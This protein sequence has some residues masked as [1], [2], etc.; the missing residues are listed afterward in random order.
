M[1]YTYCFLVVDAVALDLFLHGIGPHHTIKSLIQWGLGRP[2]FP[3]EFFWWLWCGFAAPQPP[4]KACARGEAPIAPDFAVTLLNNVGL[5]Q[6][7]CWWDV[8]ERSRR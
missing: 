1:A 3:K 6:R 2:R 8:P 5:L 4:E 7:R